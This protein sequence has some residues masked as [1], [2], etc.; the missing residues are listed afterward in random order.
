ME[1]GGVE[2]KQIRRGDM[3]NNEQILPGNYI[4]YNDI[5]RRPELLYI[6]EVKCYPGGTT[7]I[8]LTATGDIKTI[9][10]NSNTS[11]TYLPTEGY[12]R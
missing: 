3:D 6:K 8:T 2:L 10:I 1:N 5:I 4:I 11:Y 7:L 9:N 12:Q